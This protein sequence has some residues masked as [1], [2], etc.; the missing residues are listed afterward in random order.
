[1]YMIKSIN[2]ETKTVGV[3]SITC[4][5]ILNSHVEFTNEFTVR[6]ANGFTGTGSAPH[7]ETKSIYEGSSIAMTPSDI[8]EHLRSNRF[9]GNTFT[10]KIF[11]DRLYEDL[12]ILGRNNCFA[13][14]LAFYNASHDGFFNTN[15]RINRYS[16]VF[17]HLCLNVLNGGIHAYTNP[18]LSDFP[19]YLLI[20]SVNDLDVVIDAHDSIQ[21]IIKERLANKEK[22]MVNGNPVNKFQTADNPNVLISC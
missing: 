21:R 8:V 19:E 9:I 20:P 13:L 5:R 2:E 3:E 15:P 14:S 1:M 7:G 6:L 22:I 10:Q 12:A 17:P 16:A 4:R 11:D 18:V